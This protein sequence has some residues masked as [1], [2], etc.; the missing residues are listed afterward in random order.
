MQHEIPTLTGSC[1]FQPTKQPDRL[2]STFPTNHRIGL[3]RSTY[4][5]PRLVTEQRTEIGFGKMNATDTRRLAKRHAR[6]RRADRGGYA[7]GTTAR[8]TIHSSHP[9]KR[10]PIINEYLG[11]CLASSVSQ[12]RRNAPDRVRR[13]S[14]TCRRRTTAN[15]IAHHQGC[16]LCP[17]GFRLLPCSAFPTSS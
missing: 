15:S 6:H 7:T 8:A 17:S 12:I 2:L 11:V 4:S 1:L 13:T 9:R 5:R 3:E 14:P 10:A 16:S